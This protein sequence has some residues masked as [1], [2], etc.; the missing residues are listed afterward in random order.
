MASVCNSATDGTRTVCSPEKANKIKEVKCTVF[1]LSSKNSINAVTSV[2][3]A[4]N[5]MTPGL[6]WYKDYGIYLYGR[7]SFGIRLDM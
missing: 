7:A 4:A 1:K 5:Y 6:G 3:D 2:T